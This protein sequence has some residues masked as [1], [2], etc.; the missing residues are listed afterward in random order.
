MVMQTRFV[1]VPAVPLEK[2]LFP[3]R[4]GF[5]SSLAPGFDLYDTCDKVRL[6]FNFP[7][8]AE[9]EY[10]CALR[11]SQQGASGMNLMGHG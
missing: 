4:I 1:V 3:R 10:E 6:N 9:A 8:R 2:E 5:P 7:T 11:N